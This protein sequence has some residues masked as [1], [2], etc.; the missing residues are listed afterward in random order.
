MSDHDLGGGD[1]GLGP[2][3]PPGGGRPDP[4]PPGGGPPDP[5]PPGDGAPGPCPPDD[6][7]SD[8]P[9]AP[10][11]PGPGPDLRG[12]PPP[13]ALA[14][15]GAPA[16]ASTAWP[17]K[18]P[19]RPRRLARGVA[20]TLL[21]AAGL[22]GVGGGGAG[23]ALELTR[24]ATKAEVA[25]A[26]QAEIASRWQRLPAGKIF[27][28]AVGYST[29]DQGAPTTARRVGIAPPA[30]CAS[31][32]DPPVASLLRRYGCVT[33]L[34]ATYLDAS[35]TLAATAG[36]VVM[37]SASA[38]SQAVDASGGG[39]TS[40][41]VRTFSLPGTVADRFGDPQRRVFSQ[42]LRVGPY[43]VLYAAG[44]TDGRVSGS[45]VTAPQLADLGSGL[46]TSLLTRLT[47]HGSACQ[48]KDIQC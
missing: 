41:G 25:A 47:S 39:P 2:G 46:V 17:E 1:D 16:T 40:T 38:A 24:T 13:D 30:T 26:V 35:G 15:L 37:A 31:A 43:V 33:V 11:W 36:I 29:S 8:P 27:P 32:L 48:M 12:V 23:L 10:P 20:L 7:W 22:A 9:G 3:F 4:F 19:R 28:A 18:L 44:Y 21:V 45:A 6:G 42:V 5:F 14:V 34:R